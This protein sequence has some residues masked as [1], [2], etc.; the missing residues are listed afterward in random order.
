MKITRQLADPILAKLSE[1]LDYKI[2]VMDEQ[3][4]IVS[5]NDPARID[6][7]HEGA[8]HV[9][10]NKNPLVI[11]QEDL[12]RYAG[13]KPGVNL[14]IEFFGEIVGVVGVTG[15]PGELYKFA[16]IIKI[17]VE[18]MIEQAYIHNQL[19]YKN[20]LMENWIYD[21]IHPQVFDGKIAE[22][23]GNH[24]LHIDFNKEVSVFLLYFPDLV[25]QKNQENIEDV[26]M[27]NQ[28]RDEIIS[29]IEKEI[30]SA[31]FYSFVDNE[32]CLL[33]IKCAGAKVVAERFIADKLHNYFKKQR[34]SLRIGIGDRQTG[35]EGYRNSY[36]HAKQ[37]L[38]L[39]RMFDSKEQTVHISEWKFIRVL[40]SIPA[41]TRHEFLE[42]YF[43]GKIQLSSD[44]I[45]TLEVLFD[46]QLKM[47]ETAAA[48]NI[49]RNTLQYRLD[50]IY[51]Q[52]G[53]DPRNFQDAATLMMLLIFKKM[54]DKQ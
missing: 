32:T 4:I 31:S 38:E 46:H 35:V 54:K 23:N 48:L 26:M 5:S 50:R 2:N 7:I 9:I 27:L 52:I 42:Q 3:G 16:K 40:A 21:L 17:T 36:F 28:K 20:K 8:I 33:A 51:K 18:V 39:M 1:F 45:H 43:P 12:D 25:R 44:S 47:N 22:Q 15:D 13:S 49:H 19:Q 14:P 53:L 34:L 37:S 6:Q 29:G 24:L 11:S 30:P 10:S 41:E